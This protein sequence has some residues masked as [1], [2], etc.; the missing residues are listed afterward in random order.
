MNWISCWVS[1]L[2]WIL[3]YHDVGLNI[4][5]LAFLQ[6]S[7]RVRDKKVHMR[8]KKLGYCDKKA[9]NPL[10]FFSFFFLFSFL[11]FGLSLEKTTAQLKQLVM[12]FNGTFLV[13]SR[14]AWWPSTRPESLS[15]FE[16]FNF[17]HQLGIKKIWFTPTIPNFIIC[18]WVRIIKLKT[19]IWCD[20]LQTKKKEEG[21]FTVYGNIC[22]LANKKLF[23][24]I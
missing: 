1:K 21:I 20:F 17:Q 2:P 23:R 14:S 8:M 9:K 5:V 10:T 15:P 3:L 7:L 16:K 18:E 11:A 22:L 19:V 4:G 6:Q 13:S 12:W 24:I